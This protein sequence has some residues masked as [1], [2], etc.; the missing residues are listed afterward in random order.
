[1]SHPAFQFD[2][3]H[4]ISEKPH[5]TAQWYVDKLGAEI[6][7]DTVARGAPQIFVSLGGMTLLVRGKREGEDPAPPDSFRDYGDF[8]SHNRWGAD[9]IG[10]TYEGDLAAYCE[11]LRAKGVT[12]SVPFKEGA[13]GLK[14]CFIEAPDGVSIELLQR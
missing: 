6:A 11:E 7:A 4:I 8:S 1:M 12:F 2:H 10:F 14:L 13:G 9:H 3:V 5:D